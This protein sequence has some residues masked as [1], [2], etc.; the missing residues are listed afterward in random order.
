MTIQELQAESRLV[1]QQMNDTRENFQRQGTVV[2]S[3]EITFGEISTLMAN[4]QGSIDAVY[5][6]IQK[7]AIHKDDVSETIQTMAATAQETAAACEEVSASTDEQL[8]A[9]QSVTTAAET[10]TG[11]SEELSLAVNRFKV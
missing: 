5:V 9:I 7:V 2:N 10:L 1:T 6:E 3:T 11:L 4:M 8:R